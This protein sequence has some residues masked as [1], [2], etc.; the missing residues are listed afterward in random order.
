MC[1]YVDEKAR[2]ERDINNAECELQC[3]NERYTQLCAELSD[4]A[5]VFNEIFVKQFCLYLNI[6]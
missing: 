3:A 2:W 6:I 5:K 4:S 1:R